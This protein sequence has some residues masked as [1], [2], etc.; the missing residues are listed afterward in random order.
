MRPTPN[1]TSVCGD[2][3]WAST[4]THPKAGPPPIGPGP[5]LFPVSGNGSP[6]TP[7]DEDPN[8]P[9]AAHLQTLLL[10]SKRGENWSPW[11]LLGFCRASSWSPQLPRHLL[12]QPVLSTDHP[13]VRVSLP[14]VHSSSTLTCPHAGPQPPPHAPPVLASSSAPAQKAC[15][16]CCPQARWATPNWGPYNS[17]SPRLDTPPQT[18]RGSLK[19]VYS[20]TLFRDPP[21]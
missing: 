6:I 1:S 17:W 18:P 16:P 7:V 11:L 4:S 5:R 13:S 19:P 3:Q 21:L 14:S 12:L 10:P 2:V 8:P 9:S 20:A 15:C